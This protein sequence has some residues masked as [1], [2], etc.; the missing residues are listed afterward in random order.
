M[1][2]NLTWIELHDLIR[3]MINL[4]DKQKTVTRTISRVNYAELFNVLVNYTTLQYDK[5]I[6][7]NV[8]GRGDKLVLKMWR[9]E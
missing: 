4:I 8:N 7:F 9:V 1:V 3:N 6:N 5:S 2:D